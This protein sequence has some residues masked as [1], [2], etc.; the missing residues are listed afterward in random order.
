MNH[1]PNGLLTGLAIIGLAHWAGASGIITLSDGV[2]PAIT[3]ADGSA[4][5][6]SPL[7]GEVE[8]N[9]N[10]G[11]WNMAIIGGVT[12]PVYGSASSPQMDIDIL[13][14]STGAGNLTVIFSDES[15]GPGSGTLIA[16][17]VG[18]PIESSAPAT[19]GYAV[20]GD[21]RNTN[22]LTSL[23][24]NTGTNAFSGPVY[25]GNC[26]PIALA[27][28]YSLSQV[29]TISASGAGGFSVDASLN[30]LSLA[31]AA[32]SGEV[33]KPYRS[34]LVASGGCP[35]NAAYTNF[36]IIS[37]SLPPG[38]TLNPLT[39]AITGTPTTDGTY[40]YVAQVSDSCGNVAN[41]SGENCGITIIPPP[42]CNGQI[43][44]FVWHDLNGN[45][46]QD[47]GEP[48]I[49]HVKV[50]LY[51]GCGVSGTRIATTNTDSTG[52][53][54]FS[55]L[56]VGIYTVSFNAP[57]GYGRTV[58][59]QGCGTASGPA[60]SNQRDSKCTCAP[61]TPCGVCVNLTPANPIDLNVDCG[62]V[63]PPG[64]ECVTFVACLKKPIKPVTLKGH[65]G[66]GGDY[67]FT[68]TG[69]PAG[70]TM[71]ATGTI[72]GKPSGGGPYDYSV[73]ITD[74]CGNKG[75]NH[76][77]VTVDIPCLCK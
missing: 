55:G 74:S 48:G 22:G 40:P 57:A 47:P 1:K 8:V 5:D 60:Y 72:S 59:N 30:L 62:Y 10:I 52:H 56:C 20:Y 43:G 68:A 54:L 35:Q 15:F 32:V 73:I 66:C 38:L 11:V 50:D 45:G 44:D 25:R 63:K 37:G 2:H 18:Q 21:A 46:C 28:P 34:A 12:K 64:A 65:G 23:L 16:G 42:P 76:C 19:V 75:T 36:T 7:T 67:T 69:L 14:S 13:T 24:A 49:P 29:V 3:V 61:G 4:A 51:A 31:C 53:Y 6:G 26:G 27:A 70:L 41:T 33:G 77:S 58:A 71:S 17:V 39:G 9:T